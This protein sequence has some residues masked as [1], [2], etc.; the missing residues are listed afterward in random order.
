MKDIVDVCYGEPKRGCGFRK[1][2]SRSKVFYYL[3]GSGISLPCDRLP[4]K[5]DVCP[6]CGS[7]L[8]FHRGFQWL[9]WRRYAGEHNECEC[10]EY[11][12]VCHPRQGERY[13]LMWVGERFYTPRS[14]TLEAER[15]GVSK[16]VPTLPKEL[17][18]G[19]TKV[20]LAHRKAWKNR[21]PAIFYAFVVKR[22]DVLV[23]AEEADE[24]WVERLREKG[25]NVIIVGR[26]EEKQIT[27]EEV[28][29]NEV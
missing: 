2:S 6:V 26:N 21:E 9:D 3:C 23:K 8:K 1:I 17:E 10:D 5:L 4:Y 24:E 22:V 28:S 11:C 18:I 14:F 29:K 15:L 16:L 12:Y 19:K 7:G 13:G 25:V 27:L 20:L